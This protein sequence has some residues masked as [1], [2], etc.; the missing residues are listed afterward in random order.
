MKRERVGAD[1]CRNAE[2]KGVGRVQ[3]VEG[4]SGKDKDKLPEV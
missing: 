1:R 3:V 2:G 4:K